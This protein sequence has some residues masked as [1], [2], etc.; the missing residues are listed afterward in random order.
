MPGTGLS[1]DEFG[2]CSVLAA[3][4]PITTAEASALSGLAASTVA[5]MA[6]RLER[7]GLLQA[8]SHPTDRRARLWQFT[9][10]GQALFEEVSVAFAEAY[11]GLL[12]RLPQA[13][14]PTAEQGMT[15]LEAALRADLALPAREVV[16]EAAA[17]DPLRPDELGML[18]AFEDF[19]RSRRGPLS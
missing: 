16:T 14:L 10:A 1:A 12:G 5:S 8:A 17:G 6:S 15:A 4:A 18:R 3:H 7:R 2:F 11:A 13:M 9:A 19:L